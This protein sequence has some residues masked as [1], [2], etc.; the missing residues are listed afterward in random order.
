[1]T[2]YNDLTGKTFYSFRV[3]KRAPDHIRANGKKVIQWEC[4]CECG[5][6]RTLKTRELTTGKRKS[7]GCKHDY[8]ARVNNT[9]HGDSHTRLH[10]IWSGMRARCYTETDYHYKWYG[11]RG[12]RVCDEWID[13]YVEFKKWALANGYSDN[14]T[15][16]RIDNAGDYSPENCRWVTMEKQSNNTRRNHIVEAFGEKHTIS[17]W[18]KQS[19]VPYD[20]LKRRL[21]LGWS[22]ERAITEKKRL[23]V[24]GHYT[25]NTEE[26]TNAKTEGKA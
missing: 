23:S 21:A 9:V 20:L 16:D 22:A 2:Q 3:I 10:N 18:A 26:S 8:Y 24:N 25:K 4:L 13:N 19:G 6:I 1:M 14:L 12:I 5:E 11:G 15:I 7:C 17:E